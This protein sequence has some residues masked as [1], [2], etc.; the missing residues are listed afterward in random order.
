MVDVGFFVPLFIL[1][2]LAA[3]ITCLWIFVRSRAL[4]ILLT[5]ILVGLGPGWM[6]AEYFSGPVVMARVCGHPGH[7]RI[8]KPVVLAQGVFHDTKDCDDCWRAVS[9]SDRGFDEFNVTAGWSKNW[10]QRFGIRQNG[11]HRLR[12][13]ANTSACPE[14]QAA[15]VDRA[16][17]SETRCLVAT[18]IAGITA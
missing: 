7:Q 4:K 16:G 8:V 13:T 15:A 10:R 12:T 3:A 2:A 6:A 17:R 11:L 14:Y 1:A 5:L 18:P 9:S